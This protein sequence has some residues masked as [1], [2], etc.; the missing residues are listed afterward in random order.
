M[1][2][3]KKTASE[4]SCVLNQSVRLDAIILQLLWL[5]LVLSCVINIQG[6]EAR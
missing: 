4:H 1:F 6:A 2:Q 3:R 5:V